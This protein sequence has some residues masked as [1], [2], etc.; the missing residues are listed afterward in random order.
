MKEAAQDRG[1]A[2]ITQ[3]GPE[4]PNACKGFSVTGKAQE[5]CCPVGL[6]GVTG[7][8]TFIVDRRMDRRGKAVVQFWFL[9]LRRRPLGLLP[10][11]RGKPRSES[12][13]LSRSIPSCQ[14]HQA[15]GSPQEGRLRCA[16]RSMGHRR[17]ERSTRLSEYAYADG[18]PEYRIGDCGPEGTSPL[19]VSHFIYGLRLFTLRKSH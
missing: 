2:R 13:T 1:V 18:R 19:L 5:G 16:A 11:D 7:E 3:T 6:A 15:G 8:E 10:L 17:D 14:P 4:P 12:G 9:M